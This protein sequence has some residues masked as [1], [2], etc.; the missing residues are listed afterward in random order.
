MIEINIDKLFVLLAFCYLRLVKASPDVCVYIYMC[1][2]SMCVADMG[3][4]V[5][6]VLSG[7]TKVTVG[8]AQVDQIG[9]LAPNRPING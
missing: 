7:P 9:L 2:G 4:L 6:E 8:R 3:C 1:L 5:L